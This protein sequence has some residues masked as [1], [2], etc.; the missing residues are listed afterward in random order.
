M[1][2]PPAAFDPVSL[3]TIILDGT[4][5]SAIYQGRAYYFE[6]HENRD[7]FESGPDEYL[8]GAPA[9]GIPIE[10][11]NAQTDRSRHRAACRSRPIEAI[12]AAGIGTVPAAKR[13]RRA[14]S[15]GR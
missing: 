1:K 10:V 4:P 12:A 7:A 9:S 13:T 14:A 3:H 15:A 5:I 11:Q 8:A 6:S 2:T